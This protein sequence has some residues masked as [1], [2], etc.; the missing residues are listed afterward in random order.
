MNG[1]ELQTYTVNSRKPKLGLKRIL[2][3]VAILGYLKLMDGC[4]VPIR[5]LELY[6]D[7]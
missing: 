6:T 4:F 3:L 7:L 2:R 1:T 5:P